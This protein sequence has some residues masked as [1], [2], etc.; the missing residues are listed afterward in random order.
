MEKHHVPVLLTEVLDSLDL[1]HRST[2]I[3][4]TLGLGGHSEAMLSSKGFSGNVWG[5]DQDRSHL[6]H[7]RERLADFGDRFQT[8]HGN[9]AELEDLVRQQGLSF[10]GILFDLGVASPH[11][12]DPERGF[13]FQ[14]D[15]PLDMRMDPT[16]ETTAADL[17]SALPQHELITMF[18][19]YGDESL[20][21]PISR[22]VVRARGE[23]SLQS[24]HELAELIRGVYQR[25]GF[26]RSERH[27]AVRVFQ[28]LRIAVNREMEVLETALKA[29]ID[30]IRPGGRIV[31]ISYHSGEDRLVKQ[32]FKEAENP[33][34]CPPKLPVCACGREP[35]LRI[36]T[37]KPVVPSEEECDQN[38]R[39]RSAKMRVAERL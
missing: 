4:A 35:T 18:R 30:L 20:A 16:T 6:D 26:R 8:H 17:L 3:D 33:C 2:I 21:V 34:I 10:D 23:K 9:F 24:T 39:A 29:A 12:D 37:R 38:P 22:A 27:P 7:A 25:K 36:L 11:L 28:A 5:I 19:K 31:V 15:G 14:Q 32:L 13:S 1:L